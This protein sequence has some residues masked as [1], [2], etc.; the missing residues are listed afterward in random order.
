MKDLNELRRQRGAIIKDM[1]ALT[2]KAD[3]EKRELTAEENDQYSRME[4]DQEKLRVEIEREERQQR[5]TASSNRSTA[6]RAGCPSR[7][8]PARRNANP[9]ASEEYRAQF[10][11]MLCRGYRPGEHRALQ[12]DSPGRRRLPRRPGAVRQQ[13]DRSPARPG[14]HPPAFDRDPGPEAPRASACRCSRPA[15]TTPTGPWS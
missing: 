4:S 13:A 14:L 1:R 2:D 9:R 10:S 15:R 11:D 6:S 5:S 12:A 7:Q 3:A 8:R